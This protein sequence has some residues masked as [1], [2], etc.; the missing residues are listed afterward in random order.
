MLSTFFGFENSDKYP[1]FFGIST[2]GNMKVEP[3]YRS[4]AGQNV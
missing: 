2:I 4:A 3:A 1:V